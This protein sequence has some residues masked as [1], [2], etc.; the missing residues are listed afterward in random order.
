MSVCID[1]GSIAVIRR[2]GA[3]CAGGGG[4]GGGR[5]VAC[6]TFKLLSFASALCTLVQTSQPARKPAA[7][8]ITPAPLAK[9]NLRSRAAFTACINYVNVYMYFSVS[10]NALP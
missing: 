1:C 4:R 7:S 10:Y 3:W 8:R 9:L 5:D 2:M 6:N